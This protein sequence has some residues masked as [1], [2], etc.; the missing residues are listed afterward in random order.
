MNEKVT[1]REITLFSFGIVFGIVGGF[2]AAAFFRL[3]DSVLVRSIDAFF[4]AFVLLVFACLIYLIV[5][6]KGKS[7]EI[8]VKNEERVSNFVRCKFFGPTIIGFLLSFFFVFAFF[9]YPMSVRLQLVTIPFVLGGLMLM[10]KRKP[11]IQE[12]SGYEFGF[13]LIGAGTILLIGMMIFETAIFFPYICCTKILGGF[14]T[15][16]GMGL[17]ISGLLRLTFGKNVLTYIRNFTRETKRHKTMM[18]KKGRNEEF[19]N[20]TI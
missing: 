2:I 18:E 7:C 15:F 19:E 10:F 6:K 5:P 12:F 1:E 11:V 9:G 14:I 16:I 3:L 17:F 8:P 20:D 13:L 4:W